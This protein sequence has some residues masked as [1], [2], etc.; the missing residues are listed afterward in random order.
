MIVLIVTIDVDDPTG[1]E[2]SPAFFLHEFHMCFA[3]FA[4]N[5][6][7]QTLFYTKS[8]SENISRGF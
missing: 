2:P 3:G 6:F 1:G 4:C 8:S 5:I 7:A